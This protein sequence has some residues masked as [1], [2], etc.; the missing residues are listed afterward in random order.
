M[1]VRGIQPRNL[2]MATLE[3]WRDC[4]L[5]IDIYRRSERNVDW[6]WPDITRL[7]HR[8]GSTCLHLH[9]NILPQGLETTSPAR[10]ERLELKVGTGGEGEVRLGLFNGHTPNLRHLSL[11]NVT[12]RDWGSSILRNLQT[13]ELSEVCC[14][15]P[16]LEK[17]MEALQACPN[18]QEPILNEFT[19][20]TEGQE[21]PA[22]IAE[23]IRAIQL[24]QLELLQLGYLPPKAVQ[25]LLKLIE[26]PNCT[27]YKLALRRSGVEWPSV[28]SVIIKSGVSSGFQKHLASGNMLRLTHEQD[29]IMSNVEPDGLDSSNFK[30]YLA[31]PFSS[32]LIL[33]WALSL[34]DQSCI[35]RGLI[36]TELR[37]SRIRVKEMSTG[38]LRRCL[39]GVTAVIFGYYGEVDRII[40]AL[41]DPG[42]L[43]DE[44]RTWIWP[45]LLETSLY[46]SA[47]DGALLV[48]MISRCHAAP[49]TNVGVGDGFVGELKQLKK[50]RVES[51]APTDKAGVVEPQTREAIQEIIRDVATFNICGSERILLNRRVDRSNFVAR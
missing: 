4:P 27:R 11:T 18:L 29:G 42:T 13:L 43:A 41:A 37:V 39:P 46:G 21:G 24:L 31:E 44:H 38:L 6:K 19:L 48:K 5:T 50:F 8:W 23:L 17:L 2:L 45:D 32:N 9:V 7:I 26:A 14:C 34:I 49:T 40:K 33:D 47:F 25:S 35:G 36:Q 10:L 1:I 28:L 3:L 15:G 51:E 16:V 22:D 12:L 30:L 20:G